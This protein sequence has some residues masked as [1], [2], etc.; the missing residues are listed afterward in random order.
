[1]KRDSETGRPSG[2]RF[3]S[4]WRRVTLGKRVSPDRPA[5]RELAATLTIGIPAH[6]FF[7]GH[8]ITFARMAQALLTE[9]DTVVL[10]DFANSTGDAVFDDTLKTALTFP[11]GNRRS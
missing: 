3:G 6:F 1:M 10:A 2:G 7:S 5:E 9:K 11:C 4:V 8:R